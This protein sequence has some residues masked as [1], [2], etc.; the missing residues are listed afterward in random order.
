MN[1]LFKYVSAETGRNILDSRRLRW[2]SPSILNDP[3]DMQF[4]FRPGYDRDAVIAMTL[5][6]RWEHYYGELRDSPFSIKWDNFSEN[7][8]SIL[9]RWVD[10]NSIK[11][12][13]KIYW[14]H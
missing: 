10:R 6:K 14:N 7:I 4:M 11:K 1:H 12:I 13:A 3:F 5:D 9:S 8:V 2:S